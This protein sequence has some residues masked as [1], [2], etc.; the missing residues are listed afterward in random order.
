MLMVCG[1]CGRVASPPDALVRVMVEP[2][3]ITDTLGLSELFSHYE[4][5]PLETV[6]EAMIGDVTGLLQ[7]KGGYLVRD[8][9]S[10]RILF[11]D[12]NGRYLRQIGRSG[13]GAGEYVNMNDMVIDPSD[14]S[15]LLLCTV[16]KKLI[17]YASDGA[18]QREVPLDVYAESLE[19]IGDR[20]FL[21][22]NSHSGNQ[23]GFQ[24]Y[25]VDR[26]GQRK[27]EWLP[28]GSVKSYPIS[29]TVNHSRPFSKFNDSEMLFSM[30]L[31]DKIFSISGDTLREYLMLDF[32][33]HSLSAEF[34][35]KTVGEGSDLAFTLMGTD[36]ARD[37]HYVFDNGKYIFFNV[38]FGPRLH[39]LALHKTDTALRAWND[40]LTG[41]YPSIYEWTEDELLGAKTA[42]EFLK[43]Y[44]SRQTRG[45]Q[46]SAEDSTAALLTED[47]NPVIIHYMK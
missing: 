22:A 20:I 25:A 24:I 19:I 34:I 11:F 27:S 9:K 7:Y 26:Q 18:F 14:S 41:Q 30:P 21:Y 47:S 36:Y 3:R 1:S 35:E 6:P 39:R 13:K 12:G 40:D 38:S 42:M 15:I 16:P 37:L 33:G 8:R 44:E 43:D 31:E 17:W 45:L 23:D 32:G 10:R 5:I 4:Y 29:M 46:S 2:D 28:Y